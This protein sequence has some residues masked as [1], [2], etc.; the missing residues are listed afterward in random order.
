MSPGI[1]ACSAPEPAPDRPAL[2]ERVELNALWGGFEESP[3]GDCRSFS[4]SSLAVELRIAMLDCPSRL[5]GA[6][7]SARL[8]EAGWTGTRATTNSSA[9]GFVRPPGN[10]EYVLTEVDLSRRR[11]ADHGHAERYGARSIEESRLRPRTGDFLTHLSAPCAW[12]RLAGSRHRRG[13]G[14]LT[15]AITIATETAQ[16]EALDLRL[17]DWSRGRGGSSAL[18][19]RDRPV[20]RVLRR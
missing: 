20:R 9:P 8:A 12:G 18:P 14:L 1:P 10:L 16:L 15:I 11:A 13:A 17:R 3:Q 4:G 6:G 5:V 2:L 19:P 7:H